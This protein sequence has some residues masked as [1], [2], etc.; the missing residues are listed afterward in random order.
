MRTIPV[1]T[2]NGKLDIP[3]PTRFD[4]LARAAYKVLL[5]ILAA[6]AIRA[7]LHS[8]DPAIVFGVIMLTLPLPI[9]WWAERKIRRVKKWT[10]A[11]QPYRGMLFV[12]EFIGPMITIPA[13]ASMPSLIQ[14]YGLVPSINALVVIDITFMFVVGLGGVLVNRVWTLHHLG[15]ER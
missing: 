11:N 4:H 10:E 5:V 8:E 9:L 12:A 1:D 15:F 13:V 3:V 7:L 2:D 14:S 6:G